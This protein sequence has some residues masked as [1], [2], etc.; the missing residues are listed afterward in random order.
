LPLAG[1]T[2]DHFLISPGK[3][4]RNL[5]AYLWFFCKIRGFRSST[6]MP[7]PETRRRKAWGDNF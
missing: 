5:C 7:I 1:N 2:I 3:H 6:R 4:C